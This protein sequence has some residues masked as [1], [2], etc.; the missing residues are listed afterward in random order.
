MNKNIP[1]V[2]CL[3]GIDNEKYLLTAHFA[4][5]VLFGRFELMLPSSP[6][7]LKPRKWPAF[8]PLAAAVIILLFI[9]P[10][11]NDW[12]LPV[13]CGFLVLMSVFFYALLAKSEVR[14]DDEGIHYTHLFFKKEM[15]WQ[16]VSRMYIKYRHHG[17][18]GSHYWFFENPDG[19]KLRFPLSMY[20]RSQL[21]SLAREVSRLRS[22]AIF[23]DRIAAMAE[24]RF[25]WYIF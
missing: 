19:K 11:K 8:L 9:S 25:P 17:K 21:Q 3:Y 10:Q 4:Y 18:T 12:T 5:P 6:I 7:L 16:D 2:D 1:V 23:D 20:S 22:S 14:A 13:T 24:G 15:T